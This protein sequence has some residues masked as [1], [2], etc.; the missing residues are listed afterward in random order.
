MKLDTHLHNLIA[1]YLQAPDEAEQ[2]RLQRA[3]E[4]HLMVKF[5]MPHSWANRKFNELINLLGDRTK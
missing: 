1:Q 4:Q 5:N 2:E 3:A